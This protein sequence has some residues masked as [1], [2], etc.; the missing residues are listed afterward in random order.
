MLERE[1][2]ITIDI[3]EVPKQLLEFGKTSRKMVSVFH[4]TPKKNL[5]SIAREG[6]QID[7]NRMGSSLSKEH[8]KAERILRDIAIRKRIG[9]DR[10]RCTFAF[11]TLSARSHLAILE[12]RVNPK[13]A[14]VADAEVYSSLHSAIMSGDDEWTSRIAN[15]YID[16]ALLLSQFLKTGS[17][18]YIPEVIIPEDV[19]VQRIKLISQGQ[20]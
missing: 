3:N 14:F 1:G 4:E 5:E 2:P 7:R 18:F 15:R 11:T 17:R 8:D 12:V 13:K 16:E 19:P 9:I 6:L 10:T 20:S